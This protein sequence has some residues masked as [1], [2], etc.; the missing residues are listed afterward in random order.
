MDLILD[1]ER[2]ACRLSGRRADSARR[3]ETEWRRY[4]RAAARSS[5]TSR[6][7]PLYRAIGDIEATLCGRRRRE[8][9][10]RRSPSVASNPNS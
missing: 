9:P 5:A 10:P 8:P 1:C 7:A 4:L 2:A 3:T 6:L